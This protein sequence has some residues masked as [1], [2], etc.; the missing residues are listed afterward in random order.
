MVIS[1]IIKLLYVD[2]YNLSNALP[3]ITSSL[4]TMIYSKTA[5]ITKYDILT[6]TLLLVDT[7]CSWMLVDGYLCSAQDARVSSWMGCSPM[8]P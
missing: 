7:V 5:V 6:N 8:G 3:T 1:D 4:L 2:I